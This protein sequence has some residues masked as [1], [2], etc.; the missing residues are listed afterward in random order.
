MKNY[1]L[2]LCLF[3]SFLSTTVSFSQRATPTTNDATQLK[4]VGFLDG[5]TPSYVAGT[6]NPR[7]YRLSSGGFTD[8]SAKFA[9]SQV[10]VGMHFIDANCT[11]Y[12]IVSITNPNDFSGIISEIRV[13][14]IGES[15][16]EDVEPLSERGILFD[17]TTNM[18]LPQWVY[19]MPSKIE[20]CLLSHMA[21]IID[22]KL[23]SVA[24]PSV[25]IKTAPYTVAS[26]DDTILFNLA[27]AAT[28][29][30]PAA[31]T[32]NG[33]TYKIGKVDESTSVLTF[34]PAI[35]LSPTVNITTL[36]YARTFVVQS[37]G[38]DWWVVNQY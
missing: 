21:N 23:S 16:E 27:A 5:F 8:P 25:L 38:T 32:A 4:L 35:K 1:R 9:P 13:A 17:P 24:S 7:V 26:A 28:V 22:R 34:S 3:V 10:T 12:R 37:N 18:L 14:A 19:E 29:T 20:S 11:M 6:T 2:L 15:A 31:N 36:N 30:L 33:K